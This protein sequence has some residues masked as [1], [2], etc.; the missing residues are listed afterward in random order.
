MQAVSKLESY[1]Q[2]LDTLFLKR[3]VEYAGLLGLPAP[4]AAPA[5]SASGALPEDGE[6]ATADEAT[7]APLSPGLATPVDGRSG[8]LGSGSG[9]LPGSLSGAGGSSSSFVTEQAKNIRNAASQASTQIS[10]AF[11]G[12]FSKGDR[13]DPGWS[14]TDTPTAP[15]PA[16]A[17]PAA[18][19]APE[20]TA[21][22]VTSRARS[23]FRGAPPQPR[24]ACVLASFSTRSCVREAVRGSGHVR[25]GSRE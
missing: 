11:R 4:A 23:F 5:T 8:P 3:E 20:A 7:S 14:S 1:T 16:E 6:G 9:A 2:A 17:E 24:G 15:A 25:S 19:A 10:G 18:A 21:P 22:P 13:K 12:L